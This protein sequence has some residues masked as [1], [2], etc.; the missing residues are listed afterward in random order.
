MKKYFFLLALFVLLIAPVYAQDDLLAPEEVTGEVVYIPFPVDIT[1]DGELADWAGVPVTTVE[2]GTMT[3]DDP[4]NNGAFTFALASDGANLYI[5]MQSVDA[6]IVTGQHGT[7][8]WNEDSL[9][10]YLNFS[11]DLAAGAYNDSIFQVNINP[12]DIGNTDPAALTITGMNSANANVSAYVF[13]TADGWGFEAAV[14]L[15]FSPA[16]G[17]EIGFQAHANGSAA[18]G[19]R[20]VKLIWSL[21]DTSDTSWQNPAV[22][23][24]GLF[25]EVGQTDIPQSSAVAAPGEA[26]PE[27]E[28]EPMAQ[29]FISVN[30]VGYFPDGIKIAVYPTEAALEAPA[31]WALVSVEDGEQVLTGETQQSFFDTASGDYVHL[32]D[33]SAFTGEGSYRLEVGE[34]SSVPF[35]IGSDIYSG[36]TR[37]A[38]AYFYHNRSGIPIEAQ[39]VGEAWARPAGHVT[40]NDVTCFKGVDTSGTEWPGCDYTLDA[41]GGWYDAG[42]FGKYV[43]NGG[44]SVWTLMNLYEFDPQ[45]FGDGTLDIPESDNGIPDILDEARWEMDFL[46]RMQVPEGQPQAGMAHHKMHSAQWEGLP[47]VP[48]TEWNNDKEHTNAALGRYLMPPSTAATLNLAAT[49]AQCARLWREYDAAFAERCLQAAESAWQAAQ[50]N[51]VFLYGDIPGQGGG[52][53]SDA[54]IEDERYWAAAELYLTTGDEAYYDAAK[55]SPYFSSGGW[56]AGKE[57]AMYWGD[58]AVLGTLSLALHGDTLHEADRQTL[59]DQITRIADGYLDVIAGEGYRVPMPPGGYSWGSNANLLNN[60]VVMAYAHRLTE[61]ERYL[62]GVAQTM[63]YVLGRNGLNF[64]FVSGYGTHS[65]TNPHHRFWAG[66]PQNGFPFPPPG[67]VA[68]GPNISPSDPA[69]Q[70]PEITSR[71]T[72][73]RYI[74][75]RDSYST[76]EVTINWNSP[77]AWVATYL[78]RQHSG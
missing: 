26:T 36:L 54:N 34:A 45:A 43:V 11:D 78:H 65:M 58:V 59:H 12:G 22:F 76:N 14:P 2:R 73:K 35:T 49:A 51:P 44:I 33:F 40:D 63:D 66:E 3:S 1:L 64:S 50:D 32:I 7:D 47:M 31:A 23:G 15:P 53:Y 68:G 21:A 10:F 71:A 42:D 20:D 27:P 57:S 46:L 74:D 30:Q 55:E 5:T 75:H 24:R 60:A 70:V 48:P 38:L 52:A 39:Y 29:Q 18:G 6:N 56:Q 13:E 17:S 72:S 41:S 19:D 16:H 25:F 4:A 67:V 62:D 9:E 69:A 8:F 28:G 77:L 61:D 37:D